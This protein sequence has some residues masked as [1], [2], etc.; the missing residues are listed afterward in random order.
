MNTY[1]V[2]VT[3]V[4]YYEVQAETPQDAEGK[5]GG[6]GGDPEFN[7]EEEITNSVDVLNETDKADMWES[8]IRY[9]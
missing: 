2:W 6:L 9:V 4:G 5:V 1:R 3:K 8:V 7:T